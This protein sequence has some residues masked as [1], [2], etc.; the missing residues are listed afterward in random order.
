MTEADVIKDAKKSLRAHIK[1]LNSLK[2]HIIKAKEPF[3]SRSM[4][5]AYCIDKYMNEHL[6]NDIEKCM[7]LNKE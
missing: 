4:F 5:A 6:K 7:E 1:F 2:D 3:L